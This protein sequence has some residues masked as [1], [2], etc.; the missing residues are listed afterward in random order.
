MYITDT[1]R[2]AKAHIHTVQTRIWTLCHV[3]IMGYFS[4]HIINRYL[5]KLIAKR[6]RIETTIDTPPLE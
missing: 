6:V 5:S 4:G 1:G 3:I 2:K